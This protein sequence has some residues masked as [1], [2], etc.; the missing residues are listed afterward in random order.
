[1]LPDLKTPRVLSWNANI[2]Q[3]LTK[4]TALQIAYVGQ[5]GMDLFSHR[6]INQVDPLLDDGSEQFGRPFTYNCPVAQGGAGRGGPCFPGIEYAAMIENLG[7]SNYN[8]LQVTLVQKTWRGLDFLAG[9]TWAH[10]L[11]NGTSNLTSDAPQDAFNYDANW[12]NGNSDIRHR[13]TLAMTY[14]LPEK[15]APL[16]L[17]KGWQAT[18]IVTLQSGLPY[19]PFDGSNDISGTFTYG[20]ERWNFSGNPGDMKASTKGIP[21]FPGESFGPTPDGTDSPGHVTNN[22]ACLAQASLSQLESFGCYQMGSA[23]MTPQE[24]KTFGNMG[25]NILR[26]PGFYNLDMS[27]TKL[28]TFNDRLKMQLRAEFFNVLNHPN[29]Y[30][31]SATSRV[32]SGTVG[33]LVFT[34]DVFQANPVVGSGGSR[35]IQLGL[36]VLW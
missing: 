30:A 31:S 6:D 13:F 10:A 24:P 35:H 5:K 20:F 16:G 7:K 26:V 15:N 8:S 1:V 19:D 25:R 17:L 34:P 14:N 3:Q 32:A 27:V 28:V 23:V 29:F 21:Y 36:K 33:Q 12:G 9:Y 22:P 11:D 18:S 4:T 2:Q